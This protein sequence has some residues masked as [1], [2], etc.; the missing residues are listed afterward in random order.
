MMN[1]IVKEL[2]LGNCAVEAE[3]AAAAVDVLAENALAEGQYREFADLNAAAVLL[4][5][6]GKILKSVQELVNIQIADEKDEAENVEVHAS[7]INH[8]E[9][10]I[11]A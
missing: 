11:A 6:A 3:Y 7:E 1:K 2:K 8:Q 9:P 10:A 4:T 5:E